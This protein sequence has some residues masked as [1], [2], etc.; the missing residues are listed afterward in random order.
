[1]FIS[2]II[3]LIVFTAIY[4]GLSGVV[5]WSYPDAF[6]AEFFYF[7]PMFPIVTLGIHYMIMRSLSKRPASFINAFMLSTVIK[8]FVFGVAMAAFA[9]ANPE[10]AVPF[11]LVFFTFYL[12]YTIFETTVILDMSKAA[13]KAQAEKK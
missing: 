5:F 1:M 11:I 2:F 12:G 8:L 6:P 9:F 4:G 10:K 7:L 13:K 3:R